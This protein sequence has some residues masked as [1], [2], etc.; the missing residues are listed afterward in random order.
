MKKYKS[1]IFCIGWVFCNKS[2]WICFLPFDV[3]HIFWALWKLAIQFMTFLKSEL[4]KTHF[5]FTISVQGSQKN[6]IFC[7]IDVFACSPFKSIIFILVTNFWVFN[8]LYCISWS[9]VLQSSDRYKLNK[10]NKEMNQQSILKVM[11]TLNE[12]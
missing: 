2:T 5:I 12:C 10:N 8:L 4:L 9:G 1:I 3:Y 6:S 11:S 7:A